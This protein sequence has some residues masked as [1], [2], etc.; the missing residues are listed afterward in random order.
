MD[1]SAFHRHPVLGWLWGKMHAIVDP[2][3]GYEDYMD[4]KERIRKCERGI[5]AR[6]S[7]GEHLQNAADDDE[8]PSLEHLVLTLEN[9]KYR[10]VAFYTSN[11]GNP[12]YGDDACEDDACEDDACEDD[13]CDDDACDDDA[14]DDDAADTQTIVYLGVDQQLLE[15]LDDRKCSDYLLFGS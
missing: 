9:L 15:D 2:R 4:I 11:P 13:A 14:C 1:G 8:Q 12:R 3:A 6:I 10:L 7:K 5:K